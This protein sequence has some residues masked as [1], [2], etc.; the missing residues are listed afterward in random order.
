MRISRDED[1]PNTVDFQNE[2]EVLAWAASANEKRPWRLQFID[3]LVRE[4]A[5]YRDGPMTVLEFGS[6]P[7]FLSE[8]MLR[9]CPSIV[10]Y[11]AL[12][13]S[14]TMLG[15]S[16]DRLSDSHAR[17]RF[18]QANFSEAQWAAHAGGPF[19]SVVTMRRLCMK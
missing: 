13:Y 14:E 11:T 5:G 6:G 9:C 12:D 15:L 2:T 7:G 19:D 4:V 16:R 10:R 3:Q 17:V 1:V 18:V 8:R